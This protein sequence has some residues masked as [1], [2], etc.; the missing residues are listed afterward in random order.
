MGLHMAWY[1]LALVGAYRMTAVGFD[2]VVRR[3]VR[4]ASQAT[5][6]RRTVPTPGVAARPAESVPYPG[7]PDPGLRAAETQGDW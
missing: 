5:A 3:I 7:G 4:I 6:E 2:A 1:V